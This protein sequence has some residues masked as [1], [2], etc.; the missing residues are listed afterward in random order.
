MRAKETIRILVGAMAVYVIM[1]A[2]SAGSGSPGFSLGPDG[3]ASSSGGG[4]GS[5]SGGDGQGVLDALTDPV[6]KAQA[7]PNQ[8]GTRLKV[9]YYSGAD[10]SGQSTG[11]MHDSMLNA[12]CA[13]GTASDGTL[14]CLPTNAALIAFYFGDAAC[15]QP[16]VLQSTGC[17]APSYG[18]S[19]T[20]TCT[21]NG[22]VTSA[23][24]ILAVSGPFSGGSYYSQVGTGPC[25]GPNPISGLTASYALYTAGAEVPPSTFVQATLQTEP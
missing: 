13:F 1:A 22:T 8:S 11:T 10:G 2:C 9:N 4:D 6:G 23:I 7:D 15:T 18:R 12:D 19:S 20:A 21:G 25:S 14:R 5:S 17:G 3:S 16:L 24:R